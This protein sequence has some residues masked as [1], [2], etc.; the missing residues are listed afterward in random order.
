MNS[1]AVKIGGAASVVGGIASDGAGGALVTGSFTGNTSFGLLSLTNEGKSAAF[2]MHVTASGAIDWVIQAGS[3]SYYSSYGNGIAH[4]GA[5]GALVTG[6]FTGWASFGS[7]SL[8]SK[9]S[10]DAFVMHV[11]ASGAID[12]AVQA[13]GVSHDNGY[14]IAH[15][16]TGGA[17]VT[18]YF[19]DDASFGSTSLRSQKCYYDA[20]VMHVTASGAIDW[21]VQTGGRS[22]ETQVGQ[23]IAHDGA[24]GAFV[25]GYSKRD[26]LS[27]D[28]AFVMHMTAKGAIDWAIRTGG[29]ARVQGHGIAHDGAGGALVTGSLIGIGNA[30]FGSKTLTSRGDNGD[31][32]VMHVTESGAINWVIQA[33]TKLHSG[34]GRGIAHDGAGGAFVT[35][36][37]T[38]N[39]SFGSKTN[40]SLGR[41]GD[42][43]VMHVT[44]SGTIDWAAQASNTAQVQGY[45]IAHDG[46]G[47]A[48]VAGSFIGSASFGSKTLTSDGL[49]A[50]CFAASFIAP[51]SPPHQQGDSD[52]PSTP[53]QPTH[54]PP[55]S[56]PLPSYFIFDVNLK[57]P[58]ILFASL[59]L[60]SL[61]ALLIACVSRRRLRRL[62]DNFRDSRDRAQL[63]LHMLKHRF[64]TQTSAQCERLPE[65]PQPPSESPPN[66]IP[67][68]PPT[69][70]GS[71]LC[72][73]NGG[74]A[75][76][77]R[78]HLGGDGS[79]AAGSDVG[80][81][82]GMPLR[83]AKASLGDA[84]LEVIDEERHDA[85]HRGR[86]TV[87]HDEAIAHA[88]LQHG[89]DW[90]VVAAA[91]GT[92]SADSVRNRWQR[93]KNRQLDFSMVASISSGVQQSNAKSAPG[94][95]AAK[96][97]DA[98]P[99]FFT[100][101][102][103]AILLEAAARFGERWRKITELLP[104]R[105][106]SSVRHRHARLTE[107]TTVPELCLVRATPVAH[108]MPM[109]VAFAVPLPW[110]LPSAAA[111]PLPW[112]LPSVAAAPSSVLAAVP[113]A[114][115]AAA[116]GAEKAFK[117]NWKTNT[118]QQMHFPRSD[119]SSVPPPLAPAP[120]CAAAAAPAVA[121]PRKRRGE[122]AGID[123][124]SVPAAT[125]TI[126]H[127]PGPDADAST[128]DGR[129]SATSPR[130]FH[131]G[132]TSASAVE[133]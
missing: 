73:S 78:G 29:T 46:A 101:R 37:F 118:R 96:V 125:D 113:A 43:F 35:G 57:W 129:S 124:S 87:A 8:T 74:G 64:E 48:L 24:G 40:T 2:V 45:G 6:F 127:G 107:R 25:T 44:A 30:S 108:A 19:S 89:T 51:S 70:G 42:A 98:T 60:L 76:S 105:T 117:W 112:P 81:E 31:A 102:E 18:G 50:A 38:G 82:T 59:L 115:P 49:P 79:S 123:L 17:L 103:D 75:G 5:G 128:S 54:A 53:H 69:C 71:S 62:A 104:G 56:P 95:H 88:V 16:G 121:A 32:F 23:G 63:D 65:V 86:W 55:W 36:S 131:D 4:D 47:G 132:G 90:D 67:P 20:F 119:G 11:T 10:S 14:G 33:S 91:V 99:S 126:G 80:S 28:E 116:P 7:L 133:L 3:T 120:P 68:G 77:E 61:L 72:G 92:R 84:S 93:I 15:D 13:G 97:L 122:A 41:N 9:G 21:A 34:G 110:P 39:P 66:S 83:A 58:G 111:V 12:W 114:A 109:P 85:V 106:E 94:V 27:F 100:P 22:S 26:A 52:Q 130:S 1:W